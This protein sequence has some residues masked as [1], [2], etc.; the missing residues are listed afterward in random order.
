MLA[1]I[2]SDTHSQAGDPPALTG[3]PPSPAKWRPRMRRGDS[4][5]TTAIQTCKPNA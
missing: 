5:A 4:G 1:S 2:G 3:V